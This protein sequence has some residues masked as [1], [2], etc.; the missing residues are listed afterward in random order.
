VAEWII[1]MQCSSYNSSCSSAA[2]CA[3]RYHPEA[4]KHKTEC[5]H[6]PIHLVPI[7]GISKWRLINSSWCVILHLT[8]ATDGLVH[9]L[10]QTSWHACGHCPWLCGVK[11]RMFWM[12]LLLG[13]DQFTYLMTDGIFLLLRSWSRFHLSG[14]SFDSEPTNDQTTAPI[15]TR[16][17]M[18]D[19]TADTN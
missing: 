4:E 11:M 7:L 8:A 2:T 5:R 15:P 10:S 16:F 12:S 9:S 6:L 13:F 3:T 18:A 14:R 19:V 17:S 1:C